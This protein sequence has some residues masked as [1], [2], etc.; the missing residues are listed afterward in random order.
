MTHYH[1]IGIGGSGL[2]AIARVLL[3]RGHKVSGSDLILSPIAENLRESGV[4]VI[5]GHKAE[6]VMGADLIIRSSAVPDDNP[7]VLAGLNAHIP[8]L[9]RVDFLKQLTSDKKVIA[10]AGTHGKTTTTAMC[11]W[12]FDQ[13]GKDPSYIIGGVSKNLVSNAHSGDGEHFIIEADEYD[14]MFMGLSPDILILTTIE[15][16]HP[17]FFPTESDYYQ[18]FIDFTKLVKPGGIIFACSGDPGIGKI[19]QEIPE[20]INLLTYGTR[21]SSNY[22]VSQI[23]HSADCGVSFNLTFSDVGKDIKDINQIQLLVPGNHNALNSAAALAVAE[24]EGIPIDESVSA[25]EKYEGTGRRFDILGSMGGITI[26]D[27]YAHHPTEIKATISAARCRY[28][29][30]EIW[31]VWQPHTYSRTRELINEFSGSFTQSDHVIVTEIYP[32]R[33]KKQDYSSKEVVRRMDHPDVKMIAELEDVKNHL[34]EVLQPGAVLL[35]LSAGDADRISREVLE[36][37]QKKG[38]L[39]S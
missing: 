17:D 10:V 4:K 2:S 16:D 13:A 25:I 1:L 36:H 35:V 38:G 22:L 6:N 7:E 39:A 29:D 20:K 37:L 14:R 11:T 23:Q 3:E 30:K 32:S 26:I 15:H 9:K 5:I 31:T 28:P 24:F 33:E 19:L 12:I 8:V 18:A 34:I 21:E 27:D